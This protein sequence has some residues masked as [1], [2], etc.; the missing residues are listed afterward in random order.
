MSLP[1]CAGALAFSGGKCVIGMVRLAL[2]VSGS[3]LSLFVQVGAAD[4]R[5]AYEQETAFVDNRGCA[6]CHEKQFQLWKSSDHAHAMAPAT[7]ESVLGDFNEAALTKAGRSSRFYKEEGR[8]F[9]ETEGSEGTRE[10]FEVLYTFGYRPLQQYLVAFPGGRLQVLDLAWD[11]VNEK[12]FLL[13]PELKAVPKDEL[14]WTGRMN[15]WNSQCSECHT[16]NLEIGYDSQSNQF[17]TKFSGINV[18]CQACH[19]PGK[20]HREWATSPSLSNGYNKGLSFQAGKSDLET[21]A[22]CH[23]RRSRLSEKYNHGIAFRDQFLPALLLEG[24]YHADG[25]IDDEVFV[26]GSFMQSKM[27]SAGVSCGDCHDPHSG[28]TR[29]SGNALCVQCHNQ[30]PPTERFSGLKA[31]NYDS[32]EHHHHQAGTPASS[33]VTCHMPEKTYME[34][35]P[36]RDHSIRVPRPD[37]SETLGVANACSNCHS[38]RAD[39]WLSEAIDKWSGTEWRKPH[40]GEALAAGRHKSPEGLLKLSELVRE[41]GESGLVRATAADLLGGYGQSAVP[42]LIGALADQEPWVRASAVEALAKVGGDRA[43]RGLLE[44]LEDTSRLVRMQSA[45]GLAGFPVPRLSEEHKTAV[46]EGLGDFTNAQKAA[47]YS[48]EA[49]LTLASLAYRQGRPDS[50]RRHYETAIEVALSHGR[51]YFQ[52]AV[53][54]NQ[55]GDKA[56]AEEILRR[57][58]R[59]V[60]DFADAHFALGLLYAEAGDLTSA[61]TAVG[62]ALQLAPDSQRISRVLR[63]IR[64]KRSAQ[65]VGRSD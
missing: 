33:C 48:P 58:I 15:T 5:F 21:C 51:V 50:A 42:A 34:V 65:G 54:L 23:S 46:A 24:F 4:T 7:S 20:K 25:Q 2:A 47:S 64:Q 17:E 22:R 45:Y 37:L 55:L 44:G 13:R 3:L 32:R 38:D 19:G 28:K 10:E 6:G 30:T 35:D 43:L 26:F 8:F 12:W 36:R 52:Y 57:G 41:P 11:T 53:F 40:Y 59:H 39:N 1:P 62:T 9:V 56:T 31:R 49:W 60:P 63:L 61:E 16:T 18:G 14:H 27:W 29:L